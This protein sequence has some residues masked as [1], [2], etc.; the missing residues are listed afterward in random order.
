TAAR[1]DGTIAFDDNGDAIAV[2]TDQQIPVTIVLPKG[3]APANGFPV[4]I[5]QHGVGGDRS[6]VMA[7][8]NELAPPGI[9]SMAIDAPFHG[10]RSNGATDNASNGRGSYMGPD[11][12]ADG[13]LTLLPVFDMMAGLDNLLAARDN[14][15][16]AAIDIVQL[17][18]LIPGCDLSLVAD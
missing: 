14:F 12:L 8:G 15:W 4:V 17:R 13:A 10:T 18:R 11:G 1:D 5:F 6:H 7:V 9:P 2:N 16:Q 3:P